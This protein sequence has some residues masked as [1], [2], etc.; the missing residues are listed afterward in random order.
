VAWVQGLAKRSAGKERSRQV[1]R[2]AR[3]KWGYRAAGGGKLP[4]GRFRATRAAAGVS[5]DPAATP[6]RERDG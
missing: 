5:A 3:G 4:L 2:R 6:V 1:R